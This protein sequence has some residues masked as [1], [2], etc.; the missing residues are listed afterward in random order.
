MPLG[1]KTGKRI[2]RKFWK[3]RVGANYESPWT[4]ITEGFWLG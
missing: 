3:V 2:E 4:D 1:S